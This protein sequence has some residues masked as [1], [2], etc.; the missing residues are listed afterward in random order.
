MRLSDFQFIR[1]LVIYSSFV[2]PLRNVQKCFRYNAS[3]YQGMICLCI[4]LY[5]KVR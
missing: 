2:L 1:E 5:E 4:K 3:N